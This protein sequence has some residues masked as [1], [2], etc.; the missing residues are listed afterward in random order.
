MWLGSSSP[1][2]VRLRQLIYG[3]RIHRQTTDLEQ[4]LLWI[5]G[6]PDVREDCLKTEMPICYMWGRG[7]WWWW[8]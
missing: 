2:M 8:G 3:N 1:T 5:L 7:G 6:D 4:P